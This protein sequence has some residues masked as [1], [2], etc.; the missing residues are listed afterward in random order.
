MFHG[1]QTF[2]TLGQDR[3]MDPAKDKWNRDI[4]N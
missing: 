3:K 4:D 2:I 1:P